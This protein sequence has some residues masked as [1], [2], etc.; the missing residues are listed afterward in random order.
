LLTVVGMRSINNLGLV[1][2][3]MIALAPAGCAT[4]A[5]GGGESTITGKWSGNFTTD[6]ALAPMGT[7]SFDFTEDASH[8]VN[9]TFSG[10]AMGNA[11]AGTF[12]GTH[13][14][15]KLQGTVSVTSPLS[16]SLAFPDATVDADSITGSFSISMPVTANGNFTLDRQ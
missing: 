9:A 10:S 11:L 1:A 8:A 6:N 14:N 12:T 3:I 7:F 13:E 5:T 16:M 4:D 15:G 2:L